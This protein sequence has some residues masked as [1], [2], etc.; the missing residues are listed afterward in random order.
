MKREYL[1]KNNSEQEKSEQGQLWKGKSEERQFWKGKS[2]NDD[3]GKQES[4]KEQFCTGNI[5]KRTI[6]GRIN[7]KTDNSE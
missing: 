5:R 4:E 6:L 3:S 2:E 7:L 1:K